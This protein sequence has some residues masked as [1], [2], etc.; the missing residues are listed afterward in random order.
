[1]R[2]TFLFLIYDRLFEILQYKSKIQHQHNYLPHNVS[3]V[4]G[5]WVFD[6]CGYSVGPLGCSSA[7]GAL[8]PNLEYICSKTTIPMYT[9]LIISTVLGWILNPALSSEKQLRPDDVLLA[10]IY[11]YDYY[12]KKGIHVNLIHII[13]LYKQYFN[14]LFP[15]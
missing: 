12:N 13:Y 1:M 5:Y 9:K 2:W 4:Y 11:A 10:D 3:S 14:T 6:F 15:I 8:E 7:L